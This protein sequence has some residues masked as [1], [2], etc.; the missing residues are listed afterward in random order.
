MI[1][2]A[3]NLKFFS[4]VMH[5]FVRLSSAWT[6]FTIRSPIA[7]YVAIIIINFVSVL[8]LILV[9]AIEVSITLGAVSI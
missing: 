8:S 6:D 3:H 5:V 1:P 7:L 9:L 4:R 2:N